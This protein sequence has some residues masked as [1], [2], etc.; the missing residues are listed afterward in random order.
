MIKKFEN[1][2][3]LTVLVGAFIAM[4]IC[5]IIG[6]MQSVWFDEAY[7]ILIAKQPIDS[8]MHLTA[9]DTHP[10]FYYLLLKAWASV[11]GWGILSL[12]SLSV[13]S[14]GG[15]VVFAGLLIK[16]LFNKKI[17]LASLPFV[18]FAP[19]L[20][21]YGFEIR[22]YAFASLIGVI[23]TYV[24]V[25]ALESKNSKKMW[26]LYGLYAI[27]VALGVYTLY[28]LVL[29]WIA[30][31]VWLIWRS[32]EN[33]E[34]IIR[35]NWLKAYC[36]S[37]ILF[38]PWFPTF[39]NQITNGALAP[40]SQSMTISNLI[41]IVSFSFLY[42][43]AW[44]LGAI[45]SLLIIFVI[46]V[47]CYVSSRAYRLSDKKFRSNLTLL[48]MYVA[49]PVVALT[50]VGLFRPMY[51]ERYLS[52][53]LIGG[54]MFIG[55]TVAIVSEKS[56]RYGKLIFLSLLAIMLLGIGQLA[57]I[58]NY[59]FQRMQSIALE[60]A[61]NDIK[62]G[63]G[64]VV[65][66]ASPY[67][68]IELSYYIPKCVIHF[69]S[70]SVKQGGGYHIMSESKNRVVSPDTE[71]VGAKTIYYVYYGKAN[72]KMPSNLTLTTHQKFDTLSVDKYSLQ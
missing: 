1:H 22:M 36:A 30:H 68:A 13:L 64:I 2:F 59:N 62:W 37:V 58:G 10:P 23:A 53:V 41:G 72:L 71:L 26:Y 6:S 45:Y 60:P 57:Q 51:V 50:L 39:F 38:L 65:L 47:I 7:S 42:Q 67:E 14:M 25:S 5:F 9:V 29:L 44:Q 40:I 69:Y 33:K 52:H 3:L 12:R 61:V 19:F 31:L 17:A 27:L 18:I 28:Y 16:K 32:G 24:L 46:V 66:A 15:A 20:L 4:S 55:V 54:M 70:D 34:S 48:A 49:I 56:K 43:P 21:R 35:S 63:N 11:F 8:L